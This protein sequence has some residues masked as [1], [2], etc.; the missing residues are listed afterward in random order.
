[1]S[2]SYAVL[3]SGRQGI[4]AA[5]DMARWGDADRVFLT[6]SNLEVAKMAAERINDLLKKE[7]AEPRQVDVTD[8]KAV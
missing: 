3:G 6:D 2:Y 7:I 8:L 4:A 1:M 5:Y